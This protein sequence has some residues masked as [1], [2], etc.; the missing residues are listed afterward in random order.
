MALSMLPIQD[1]IT[2]KLRELNQ[3]VYDNGVPEDSSLN[4]SPDG[5]MLPYIIIR[6]AGFIQPSSERGLTGPREDLGRSYVECV[7]MGPNE[8][9]VRQVAD[10]VVD[11]LTGFQPS[12]AGTLFPETTGKPYIVP[13]TGS[14]PVRYASEVGFTFAVNTVIS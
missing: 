13:D 4:Y 14:R 10:L 12:D 1:Q 3:D 5:V 9:T 8:R 11:K 7:C 2:T 6:Y